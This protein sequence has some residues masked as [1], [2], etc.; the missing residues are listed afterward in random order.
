MK[1]PIFRHNPCAIATETTI[2]M[3]LIRRGPRRSPE[4]TRRGSGPRRFAGAHQIGVLVED[5]HLGRQGLGV[6]VRAHREPVGPAH[7]MISRSPTRASGNSRV[8]TKPPSS[9]VKMSPIRRAGRPRP[10]PGGDGPVDADR[11]R[12]TWGGKRRR[13]WAAQIVEPGVQDIEGSPSSLLDCADLAE[14]IAALGDQVAARLD[15]QADWVADA[16][17]SRLRVASQRRK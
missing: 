15:L 1:R 4:C 14:Q 3:G 13:E 8:Q 5:E 16:S 11:P 12:P 10:R 6:V 7:S 17:A 2:T 9:W